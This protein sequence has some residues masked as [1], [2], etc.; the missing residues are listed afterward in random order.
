[1]VSASV[2]E[3]S[4]S[5]S[6][7]SGLLLPRRGG[8]AS[9]ELN[10]RHSRRLLAE[11]PGDSPSSICH[12]P[13]PSDLPFVEESDAGGL[14][15]D[16]L[17]IL[18]AENKLLRRQLED[19]PDLHR[20]DVE[21]RLLREHLASLV[22]QHA[23]AREEPSWSK[24]HKHARR[25]KAGDQ[26]AGGELH[27]QPSLTRTSRSAF[28]GLAGD[29][30]PSPS[31][32]RAEHHETRGTKLTGISSTA[33]L[34]EGSTLGGKS[35]T[36]KPFPGIEDATQISP[37]SSSAGSGDD[38]DSD[39][40]TKGSLGC[41]A[42]TETGSTR[43]SS[44]WTS[45]P[46][47]GSHTT[48]S[49]RA[50]PTSAF[51]IAGA[52]DAASFLPTMARKVEEL[53]RVK[54]SLEEVLTQLGRRCSGGGHDAAAGEVV[55][56]R[57]QRMLHSSG[58]HGEV[59]AR[60]AAEILRGTGE[61]LHFAENML[62][63]GRGETLLLSAGGRQDSETP[64]S[65]GQ[66]L[67]DSRG[68]EGLD[69]RDVFLSLMRSLPS[70]QP[71]LSRQGTAASAPHL[72]PVTAFRSVETLAGP[73]SG[74]MA[75]TLAVLR[76]SSS[77]GT[78][79][80]RMMRTRSTAQLHRIAEQPSP[81]SQ[82]RELLMGSTD[83]VSRMPIPMKEPLHAVPAHATM[84]NSGM[85]PG[86]MVKEAA[87]RAHELYHHLELVS[88]AYRDMRAQFKPLK[89]EYSRKMDECR[90]LEGQCQRLD[91]HC[92][93]LEEQDSVV[94]APKV[95]PLRLP[96]NSEC[97]MLMGS[98]V[99]Q[100]ITG[101]D[102]PLSPVGGG[103]E[104]APD[105]VPGIP[106]QTNGVNS[107][108]R[109]RR[110]S[111]S[112]IAWPTHKLENDA[113]T[114]WR[115]GASGGTAPSASASFSG[116]GAVRMAPPRRALSAASLGAPAVATVQPRGLLYAASV[117]ELRSEPAKQSG[118]QHPGSGS[119][120]PTED[121]IRRVASAPQLPVLQ[122]T[123][124]LSSCRS[125]MLERAGKLRESS[126]A[127][128]NIGASSTAL[129]C[130]N[131]DPILTPVASESPFS[132]STFLSLAR[133]PGAKTAA[134]K[135]LMSSTSNGLGYAAPSGSDRPAAASAARPG[136]T[137]FTSA[138]SRNRAGS[139]TSASGRGA[140]A[141]R[142]PRSAANA[143]RATM[144]GPAQMHVHS[145]NRSQQPNFNGAPRQ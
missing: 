132:S 5:Y 124:Q 112:S 40:D 25:A 70:E 59:D 121:Y 100:N 30:E 92:R 36:L 34:T 24:G 44:S 101:L 1:M 45:G 136:S 123:P 62:A 15:D 23:L 135:Y 133:Q 143:L 84:T 65:A 128:A 55:Q 142:P 90:F 26:A 54:T 93:R 60:V 67:A 10:K 80:T 106:G 66:V 27:R 119:L 77:T 137:G 63:K 61:A 68:G 91:V 75:A 126:K 3:L 2:G 99:W 47:V 94:T 109:G 82:T 48:S 78:A 19:H 71:T 107:R 17:A 29:S 110:A 108:A 28:L 86:E 39:S 81:H 79:G 139:L 52:A 43:T 56:P 131:N 4:M 22:H 6:G 105:V 32:S 130:N 85:T 113:L 72:S 53:L 129:A 14:G 98:G 117:A 83:I 103:V 35:L 37:S 31:P 140:T 64:D 13:T 87:E 74:Q 76:P 51:E 144:A 18:R 138:S 73:P 46:S 116:V 115:D 125:G 111:A 134:L 9:Q 12:S 41:M 50:K 120:R 88:D 118:S 97:S 20:H 122:S 33:F 38:A 102:S 141:A 89:D 42:S 114:S 104:G 96:E 69:E 8:S 57:P 95:P 21:N 127:G 58:T 11:S 7:R 16:E 145:Q 49:S